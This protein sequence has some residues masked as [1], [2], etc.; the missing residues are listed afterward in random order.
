MFWPTCTLYCQRWT[1][2]GEPKLY[3]NGETD[4]I[5]DTCHKYNKLLDH[6]NEV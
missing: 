3:S 1:K 6:G 4:L 5:K 2:Y